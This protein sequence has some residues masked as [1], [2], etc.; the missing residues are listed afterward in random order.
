MYGL[1]FV[2]RVVKIFETK[3]LYYGICSE[4]M[5]TRNRNLNVQFVRNGSFYSFPPFN[6]IFS[7]PQSNLCFFRACFCSFQLEILLKNHNYAVHREKKPIITCEICGKSFAVKANFDKH[8]L[9]HTDKSER[10]A[11]SKQCEHCGE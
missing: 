11:Q 1:S 10:L 5:W 9:R 3:K 8:V 6:L 2:T 7:G 4:L